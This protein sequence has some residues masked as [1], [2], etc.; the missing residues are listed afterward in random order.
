MEADPE[1]LPFNDQENPK[2]DGFVQQRTYSS[3]LS[4]SSSSPP[5][6]VSS[7][8]VVMGTRRCD[9]IQEKKSS[10][11]SNTLKHVMLKR[12]Y[13]LLGVVV[14]IFGKKILK[15]LITSNETTEYE[16]EL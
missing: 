3:T 4:S 7:H 15:V 11:I 16:L 10:R 5:R 6:K 1:M 14:L 2:V 12:N 8:L 9:V 13:Y